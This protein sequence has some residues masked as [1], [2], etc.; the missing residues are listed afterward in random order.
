MRKYF[1]I[2][3]SEQDKS[4]VEAFNKLLLNTKRK[5]IIT[6]SVLI[7]CFVMS[8][9]SLSS[10]SNTDGGSILSSPKDKAIS[11]IKH[12]QKLN[13]KIVKD[14]RDEEVDKAI[15]SYR[16]SDKYYQEVVSQ[17]EYLNDNFKMDVVSDNSYYYVT[18]SGTALFNEINENGK[19]SPRLSAFINECI[20]Y[21]QKANENLGYTLD[22]IDE[23]DEENS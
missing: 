21:A 8:V 7:V 17:D 10:N 9:Y 3:S 4:L 22:E 16:E 15:V 19:D 2:K 12:Y 14:L 20:G 6:L 18:T 5:R 11:K 23:I 1:L 13:N